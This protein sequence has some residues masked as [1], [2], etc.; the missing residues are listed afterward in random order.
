M[1]APNVV[2]P[3]DEEAALNIVSFPESREA[4]VDF[5]TPVF[6]TIDTIVSQVLN[7]SDSWV[8]LRRWRASS[9]NDPSIL[10]KKDGL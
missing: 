3:L 4:T 8:I 10:R 1:S 6:P 7:S 9:I 5:P 2:V